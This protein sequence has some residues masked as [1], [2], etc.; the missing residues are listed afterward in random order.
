MTDT[1]P[2]IAEMVRSRLMSRSGAER[3]RNPSKDYEQQKEGPHF[4]HDELWAVEKVA[5]ED[6][7]GN[8]HRQGQRCQP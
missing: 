6:V 3:F 4:V 7:V 2:E 5:H 8:Q 1:P